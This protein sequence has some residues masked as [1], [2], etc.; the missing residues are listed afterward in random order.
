[1][2]ESK[3][4]ILL[5]C[6]FLPAVV[7][8]DG[9][10][11]RPSLSL[12][13]CPEK[14]GD[15]LI[16]YPFGIGA[17]CAATNLSSYF[18]LICNDT[19]APPRPTLGDITGY[20]E[21]TNIS[22]EKSEIRVLIP[23]S[24]ICF[25][26]N[27]SY[28]WFTEGY[29]LMEISP[30]RPSSSRNRFTVIGCNTL[31]V[32]SGYKGTTN[33]YVT[34]CYSYCENINSTSDGAQCD[35]MG[36]CE[37]AIPAN[38]TAVGA[39]FEMNQSRVW[40]FNP[41]FYAM[42]AEVGWYRFSQQDLRD[43]LGF[44]NRT[45][46]QGSPVIVDW[47]IRNGSCPEN[48]QEPPSDYACKSAHSY[49]MASSNGPGYLCQCSDG[50]EGLSVSAILVMALSCLLA[51]QLQ[52]KRY[53]KEK[54]EYFRQNGGLKLYDEMRSRKVDT[55]R[56]LTER[57]IKRATNNYNEDQ[58]IGCGGHGMVY[59]GILYDHKE[60]AI[61]KSK[62]INDDS[63]EEFVNEIIILSQINHR[64]IVRLLGCCLDVDVPMLVYEF[65]SNGTLSEFLHGANHRPSIPLDL[66]LKI[67]TE[68]AEALAYLHSSTSSTVLHGDV[69]SANILLDD[70]HNAK[71]ADF[72]ASALKSMN[73]SE[74]I[75]L[76]QGTLGYLDPESFIAHHLTDKSD[77]YSFGVVLLELMTR[78]R[79]MYID[80]ELNEKKSL[81]HS[82]LLMFRQN[83]HQNMLD[84]DIL[85]EA[86]FVVLEKLAK[87]AVH[88]LSP[89]GDNR[90][91]M[92]E[93]AERLQILRRLHM[94]ATNGSQ[95]SSYANNHEVSPSAIPS[96]E[97]TY[98]KRGRF[99]NYGDSSRTTP[100]K[101]FRPCRTTEHH[102]SSTTMRKPIILMLFI[103]FLVTAIPCTS[104]G[105]A[106]SLPGCP[107]KCGNVTIPYPFGIGAAC[108]AT[109]L[110]PYFTVTCN[111]TFQ[112]PRPT[113]SFN[114]STTTE[115]LNISLKHGEMRVYG[116]VSYN[117]YT[118]NTTMSD[119]YTG[120]YNLKGTPF[121]PSTTRNRFTGI[122][123]NTL[124]LIGGYMHSNPELYLAGCYS[125]CHGINSTMH[126]APCT[127]KGCCE[128]TI[129]SNLTDFAAVF[130]MN[131]SSVWTFNPCFYAMLVE[132][133][134]YSFRR[135]DLV[136]RLGFI[137]ERASRG[138]PVIIDWAIRNGSC[139][140]EGEKVPRDYAC[141][142]SNSYCVDASNGP[143]YL[144]NCSQGY[145]GNPYLQ[146]GC[147]GSVFPTT[148]NNFALN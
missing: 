146:N 123:C 39:I 109:S 45:A 106:M 52:R 24:Y 87:L 92:K 65:V 56:I 93:V 121:I 10:S 144:C 44:I 147:Q 7:A 63:R 8:P 29:E 41:C 95:N 33:Q 34:G 90:P 79:A 9:T 68:S 16:P 78:K 126:G 42:V 2:Q 104:S 115:V 50:Y 26:S 100:G 85:E 53:K 55:V 23:V 3:V 6:I 128:A 119:N 46:P 72:G 118:S 70:E 59:R 47:A 136:G 30:F 122:G 84:T 75:M 12:P 99:Q 111:T 125:Y 94:R 127:G 91:T 71:V 113:I 66:R 20:V 14:C 89:S 73:E 25:T 82:F 77:V 5:L 110:N 61:K 134:W 132:A 96:D 15:V 83:K 54:D 36:C 131:E 116:P 11:S 81:S 4:L 124:G 138:V 57:D 98:Q 108:A 69:K 67:A 143:G 97:M 135:Q 48:G 114:S 103:I 141:V 139:P 1:M 35:G 49:C 60:V 43:R 21:I 102:T 86:V 32:I 117:C 142:S 120:E 31:G 27:T 76:V 101:L 40:N 17:H 112:P 37:A 140:K 145:E 22:L 133:G 58:V 62:V 137:N 129:S 19:L 51:M 80:D 18:D 74:F 148:S 105:L 28:D 88:C 64:N 130:V 38:L 13:G 107:D